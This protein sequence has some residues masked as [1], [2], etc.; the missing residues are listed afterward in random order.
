[1]NKWIIA[2]TEQARLIGSDYGFILQAFEDD[3]KWHAVA[4][5]SVTKAKSIYAKDYQDNPELAFLLLKTLLQD[6]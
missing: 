2:A 3:G 5:I 1:M 4:S 6:I